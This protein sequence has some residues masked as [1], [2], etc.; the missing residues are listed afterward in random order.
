MKI[1]FSHCLTSWEF[2]SKLPHS[3][4]PPEY[5]SLIDFRVPCSDVRM[6]YRWHWTEAH[7][8]GSRIS[9]FPYQRWKPKRFPLPFAAQLLRDKRGWKRNWRMKS[10][11]PWSWRKKDSSSRRIEWYEAPFAAS[12][13]GAV[14]GQFVEGDHLKFSYPCP[15]PQCS[16]IHQNFLDF[17]NI[18]YFLFL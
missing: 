5:A 3:F 17:H 4:L 13:H 10:S 18:R 9:E 8:R 11:K 15:S 7:D 1:N 16:N 12:E 14:D 6:E 2:Q